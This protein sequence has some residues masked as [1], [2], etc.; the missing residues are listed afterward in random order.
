EEAQK[1]M[2]GEG[3]EEEEDYSEPDYAIKVFQLIRCASLSNNYVFNFD[4]SKVGSL[5][6]STN[7]YGG[8]VGWRVIIN[9]SQSF[10]GSKQD[11]E[12]KEDQYKTYYLD[13]G[14]VK[15]EFDDH[16]TK[17]GTDTWDKLENLQDYLFPD[18]E[19]LQASFEKVKASI[20]AKDLSDE[21]LEDLRAIANCEAKDFS[22]EEKYEIIKSIIVNHGTWET[23]EDLILDIIENFEGD[24]ETYA[25]DILDRLVNDDELLK[26]L[27]EGIQNK[28]FF[29]GREDNADRFIQIIYSLWEVS[30]YS[31]VASYQYIDDVLG[32]ASNP[33]SP[34][35]LIYQGKSIF[36]LVSYEIDQFKD[37][38]IQ[39]KTNCILAPQ[40]N[41]EGLIAYDYLQ[42]VFLF[43]ENDGRNVNYLSSN[44]PAL[45]FASFVK[46]DNW[47]RF[48]NQTT[49][50]ADIILTFTG[51]GNLT[52]LRHLSKLE[53]AGKIVLASIE[54]G[55]SALD[56]LLNYTELCTDDALCNNLRQYNFYLQMMLLS[57]EAA[58]SIYKTRL[59][60]YKVSSAKSYEESR[61]AL[62]AK[63]GDESDE[64][65]ALDEH[66]G[67]GRFATFKNVTFD[68]FIKTVPEFA[69]GANTEL[70]EQAYRLWGEEKWDELYELFVNNNFNGSWPPFNGAKSILKTESGN[71]LAGKIFDRFQGRGEITGEFASPVYGSEGIDDLYFTYDS[72]ALK[73]EISEQTQYL[74]F[75]LTNDIPPDVKFTYAEVIPWWGK[76]GLGDQVK[77]SQKFSNLFKEG[78]IEIIERWEFQQGKWVKID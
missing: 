35:S 12:E 44:I 32:G 37:G 13:Y 42:P 20:N 65:K 23:N 5:M 45:M 10:K 27:F 62:V 21:D 59:Q 14:Q 34:Y 53:K 6:Y 49:L 41:Q 75:K 50:G 52:K 77:S 51:I 78:V 64:V 25:Q 55:S 36:P 24:F 43:K 67:V 74:K 58:S 19:A 2:E 17:T 1:A 8:T 30:T 7:D 72:R 28:N 57:G 63:Y 73:Y 16:T 66:F 3:S 71:E 69:N 54:F 9:N 31:N 11:I 18:S 39:I 47:D 68:D 61:E 38:K 26:E 60:E 40:G 15:I 22:A 33:E 4:A 76:Q 70:A 56:L 48:V 46:H 29:F